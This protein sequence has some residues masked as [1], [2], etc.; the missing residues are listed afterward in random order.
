MPN[1]GEMI[2]FEKG[3][4]R[5]TQRWLVFGAARR[6]QADYRSDEQKCAKGDCHEARICHFLP[7]QRWIGHW[8]ALPC[9][10]PRKECP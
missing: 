5:C 6:P 4:L 8:V 7:R 2:A 3:Y 10:L 1:P 9:H